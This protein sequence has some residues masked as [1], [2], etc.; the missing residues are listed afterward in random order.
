MK[1]CHAMLR[2]SRCYSLPYH[3][4]QHTL[5]VFQFARKISDYENLSFEDKE[6]VSLA[7]LFHDTG[8]GEIFN[9]HEKISAEKADCFLTSL[10]YSK[11]KIE[12]VKSCIVATKMPQTPSS[13][14]EEVICDADLAHLGSGS[15]INYNKRLRQEWNKCFNKSY[16][17]IEWIEN[18]I[19]FLESHTYFTSYGKDIL[20]PKKMKNLELL[21]SNYQELKLSL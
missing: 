2:N 14:L 5:E 11:E 7:S 13:K 21:K 4:I 15:F 18:N 8:N 1:H 16:S 9:G 3:N 17:D 6:V 12:R 10:G 19:M 20:Q